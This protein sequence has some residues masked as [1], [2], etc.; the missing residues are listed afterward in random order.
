[1]RRRA[2]LKAERAKEATVRNATVPP[3]ALVEWYFTKR[4]NQA[5]PDDLDAYVDDIGLSSRQDFYRLLQAEYVFLQAGAD[6][7]DGEPA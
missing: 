4:L 7:L 1:L 3:P 2:G 6:D 5:P